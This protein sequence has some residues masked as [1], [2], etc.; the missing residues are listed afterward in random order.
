MST[1]GSR[2]DNKLWYI[3]T[4]KYYIAMIKKKS[5]LYTK[6]QMVSQIN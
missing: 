4:M 2:M 3:C 5:L 1:N 6:T